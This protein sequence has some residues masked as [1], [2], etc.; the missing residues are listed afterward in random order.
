MTDDIEVI[1]PTALKLNLAV[2]ADCTGRPEWRVE[3][4]DDDGGCYVT[5]FAGPAAEARAKAYWTA[6]SWASL[7]SSRPPS[8]DRR[9]D[10]G[11][12]PLRDRH[13]RHG[14]HAS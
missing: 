8:S 14:A 5:I 1:A 13:R 7:T 2:I 10:F 11:R 3:Y 9:N 4:F 12:R 6:C